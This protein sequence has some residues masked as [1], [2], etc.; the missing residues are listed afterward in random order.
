MTR[1]SC[2]VVMYHYVRDTEGTPFPG[3]RALPPAL[4]E[5]QLDW[6]QSEYTLITQDE[7]EAAVI[8]GAPLPENPA[9]LTFD[10]GFVDHARTA[11][12]ILRRRGL[13]G[14]FFISYASSGPA[15]RLLTV[16]QT[17]LLLAVM[18]AEAFG[19]GVLAECAVKVD[20]A[21]RARGVF[22]ADHWEAADDRAIKN[23]INYELP[24]EEA[25]RVLDVLCRRYVGDPAALARQLYVDAPMVREMADGGMAIGYH[26]RTHRMLS[27]LSR[28]EQEQE[29]H[30]GVEWIR[31]MTGQHRVSFCY[32]WGG[33]KTYTADTVQ[34][35]GDAGYSVA[36]TSVRR[37]IH[38]GEDGRFDLPR[39]DT[40]D[41]PPYTAGEA[42][43]AAAAIGALDR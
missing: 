12:P 4:F 31:E 29:L 34:I 25:E 13:S 15:P 8:D 43:A 32:P 39:F 36:F 37:R 1:P 26:T 21:G 10:D 9:L 38:V 6:L 16:H 35:L 24:F 27:R 19:R 7:L 5:Q 23:L 33:P 18:G 3:I 41:L 14:V 30:G 28:A 20:A 42:D 22:G 40:R 11:F 2:M 17:H